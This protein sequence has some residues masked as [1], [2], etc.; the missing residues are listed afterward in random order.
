MPAF[1]PMDRH[2]E[3]PILEK[4]SLYQGVI[5]KNIISTKIG[6]PR[7]QN[8]IF[9]GYSNKSLESEIGTIPELCGE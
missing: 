8:A 3:R 2:E 7:A 4:T 9:V 6:K 5:P 1:K